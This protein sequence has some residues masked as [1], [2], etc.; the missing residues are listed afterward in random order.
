MKNRK[1]AY[2]ALW[3]ALLLSSSFLVMYSQAAAAGPLSFTSEHEGKSNL[4][5][6]DSTGQNL[7]KLENQ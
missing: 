6:I 1:F 2:K 7:Q 5:L 4:Y 3:I